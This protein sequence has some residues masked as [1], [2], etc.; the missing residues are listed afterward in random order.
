MRILQKGIKKEENR[1]ISLYDEIKG[2]EVFNELKSL[3]S[4]GSNFI[5]VNDVSTSIMGRS[6]ITLFIKGML[7][8]ASHEVLVH[9][10]EDNARRTVRLARKAVKKGVP[11]TVFS[12]GLEDVGGDRVDVRAIKNGPGFIM[13]DDELLVFTS[14]QDVQPEAE[15]A[16][17]VQSGFAAN[18]L[19]SIVN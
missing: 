6:D 11:I 9:A 5:E 4:S 7:S 2:T 13:V 19:R 12:H 16:V 17:W 10:S 1:M 8:R 18:M 15:T 14:P 3:Y